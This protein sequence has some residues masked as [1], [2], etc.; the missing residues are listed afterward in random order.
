M[1][2]CQNKK[3]S[4]GACCGIFNLDVDKKQIHKILVTRT[5]D[6]KLNVIYSKKKTVI[7]FREK[8]EELE[9]EFPKKDVYT[10]NCPFLGF[11]EEKKI[12]CMIHPSS[13]GDK[14][15]QNYSFYGASICSVYDC[16]NKEE[17]NWLEVLLSEMNLDYYEYSSIASNHIFVSK[18]Q[19]LFIQNEIQIDLKNLKQK[20]FFEILIMEYLITK[21]NNFT[22][23]ELEME[24]KEKINYKKE[25][26]DYFEVESREKI[27]FE[28]K[29]MFN[30]E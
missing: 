1:S 24:V 9:L 5:N 30:K 21:K 6:F 17:R 12:G 3:T 29:K 25:L 23:F 26:I 14:N 18:I 11:I 8:F 22:S 7:E 28:I 16:K 4:C 19:N 20:N 15:S 2:L 10:Y 13:T 27:D